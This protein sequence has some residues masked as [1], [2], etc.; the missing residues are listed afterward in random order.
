MLHLD[1]VDL[2]PPGKG[3]ITIK[4]GAIGLNFI[5]TYHRTGLYPV[6]AAI[7][8]GREAAGVVEAVGEGVTGL[9]PGDR[10]AYGSGGRRLCRKAHISGR[11][12]RET[13]RRHRRR[14]PPPR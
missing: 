14:A 1:A 7:G 6:D 8:L 3:E 11:P 9:A 5:D 12:R 2:P 13:P 4:H 10:V